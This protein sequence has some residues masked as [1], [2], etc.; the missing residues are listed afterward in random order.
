MKKY[1]ISDLKINPELIKIM[2]FEDRRI[3]QEFE[4]NPVSFINSWISNSEK[5]NYL[6]IDEF[7][8]AKD[9]GQ[10]LKFVHDTL[11]NVK[12]II[13]GSSSLEIVSKVKSFMTGRLLTFNMY[14]FNFNEF[15]RFKDRRLEKIYCDNTFKVDEIIFNPDN[16]K[17]GL[18]KEVSD[19][20]PS[21]KDM[22]FEEF[23]EL[24]NEYCIWGGYP[25]VIMSSV[26]D[27]KRKVLSEIFNSYILYDIKG[28][29]ELNTERELFLLAQIL[30]AQIGSIAV[31]NNL[32]IASGLIYR[33][34]IEHLNVL[35]STF[36]IKE[37]RPY[38]INKQKELTKN[39][40]IYFLDNGFRN[41]LI[42]NYNSLNLRP[43]S[44]QIFEQ[45]VFIRLNE[46]CSGKVG[47]HFWRTK[48]GAEVDFI[49][50]RGNDIVPIEVKLTEFNK[51][52]ITKSLAS[53]INIFNPKTAFVVNKNFWGKSVVSN[54][55]VI[56][57]PVYY[58]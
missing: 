25:S 26:K 48:A 31:Y 44:G 36:I 45:Y 42:E 54:T 53:F 49:F 40:K 8:Y 18:S 19:N 15:L 56:F 20:L 50:L 21:G 32:S 29:L 13:T 27:E 9:G 33:K 7:Q 57:I 12:I 2:S 23:Y 17:K 41:Y 52:G 46:I 11:K 5:I 4:K 39:Q 24:F 1:L 38:F 47:L 6:L 10:K 37:V 35:K 14:P 55:K 28:L 43:D 34:L 22:Y 16:Y 30:A 58:L 3:L 51:P